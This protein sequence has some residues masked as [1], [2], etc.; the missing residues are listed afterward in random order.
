M[1]SRGPRP[2]PHP[3]LVKPGSRVRGMCVLSAWLRFCSSVSFQPVPNR[4]PSKDEPRILPAVFLRFAIRRRLHHPSALVQ[5][6][7]RVRRQDVAPHR[8]DQILPPQPGPAILRLALASRPK[9]GVTPP[10]G[11]RLRC[12]PHESHCWPQKTWENK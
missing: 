9:S 10:L 1:L 6:A 4:M 7:Q 11:W 2:R 8:D 5:R 12:I 3:G